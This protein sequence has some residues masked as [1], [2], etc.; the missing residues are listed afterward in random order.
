MIGGIV[1]EQ[2]HEAM[3]KLLR[4]K[5]GPGYNDLSPIRLLEILIARH[6][7]GKD[8]SFG[9]RA[10]F[11]EIIPGLFTDPE[12]GRRYEHIRRVELVII[13]EIRHMKQRINLPTWVPVR[14]ILHCPKCITQHVDKDE[15][16]IDWTKRLHRKHLCH[17]CGHIWKV[18]N[19][20]TVGVK[21]LEEPNVQGSTQENTGT[22]T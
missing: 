10:V 8:D 18:A 4:E 13:Q 22:S 21:D 5:L 16:N 14:M 3:I 1:L 20:Y 11:E 7:S 6:D 12:V 9:A 19:V 2:E 17:N 15:G